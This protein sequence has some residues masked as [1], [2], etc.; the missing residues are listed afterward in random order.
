MDA[1][2]D[3]DF[4]RSDR[5]TV[6]RKLGAGGMGVVFEA[7][8]RERS[9]PVALK[10]LHRM[11]P[12]RLYA[13]KREFRSLADLRHPNLIS[14]GELCCE[15]G[16]WFFTMELIRGED[17]LHH[18]W[19]SASGSGFDPDRLLRALGGLARGIHALHA[20]GKIHRDIK[21]SNVMVDGGG[22]VVLL[23]FGLASDLLAP[24]ASGE[25]PR[26]G[27]PRYM[28]PEVAAGAEPGPP[29]DWYSVGAVLHCALTGHPPD[30]VPAPPPSVPG[31]HP[32]L[33]A[34]WQLC[35]DLLREDPSAR[36]TGAQVLS[37]LGAGD[38]RATPAPSPAVPFVGRAAE[39]AT[40]GD[41]AARGEAALVLV[42]GASGLG[43][44]ALARRFAE[45]LR[46]RDP[47]ALAL[48]GR[49]YEQESVPH[50]AFDGAVDALSRHL[51]ALPEADCA[52]LLPEDAELLVR[53]FP[54]LARVPSMA[55]LP[56]AAAG[57]SPAQVRLRAYEAFRRLLHGLGRR[58]PLLLCLD[59]LQWADADSLELLRALLKDPGA[60]PVLVVATRRPPREGEG[61]GALGVDRPA[62]HL[63]LS[64][65]PAPDARRLAEAA[66]AAAGP[67]ADEVVKESG[68]H[69]LYLQL[70]ARHARPGAAPARLDD[71]VWATASSLDAPARRLLEVL[72]VA[73]GPLPQRA[74]ADAAG[75][76]PAELKHSL[77]VLAAERLLS[78]GADDAVEP[79]HDRV[80]EAVSAHLDDAARRALHQSLARAL[81]AGA[82][83]ESDPRQLVV[84]LEATGETAR[85]ADL[86]ERSARR[87]E[88]QLAFDLAI[89]LYRRAL[90]LGGREASRRTILRLALAQVLAYAGRGTEAAEVFLAVAQTAEPALALEARRHAAEQLLGSGHLERGLQ[91]L[92]QV[93]AE[94]GV[95][96]PP[97]ANRAIASL[98]WQRA[99]LALR[100]FSWAERPAA[101]VPARALMEIDTL[102]SVGMA[103]WP[104]DQFRGVSFVTRS[105]RLALDAG[106]RSRVALAFGLE[107][108][109]W[110]QLGRPPR[111]R[112]RAEE[113]RRIAAPVADE[114]LGA[115]LLALDGVGSY[116]VGSFEESDQKLLEAEGRR[117]PKR[118]SSWQLNV[119]RLMR[120]WALRDRGAYGALAAVLDAQLKEAM[121]RGDQYAETN[122][123]RVC[124]L[125]WLAR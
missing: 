36:P 30:G 108:I 89:E 31:E 119:F 96:G 122:L 103:L 55:S 83:A 92:S 21:P 75:L 80:K 106:E 29:S 110:A 17:F 45:V 107:A 22:R 24:D 48:F 116:C 71:V 66:G 98:F 100:G 9:A 57:A 109:Y 82:A 56:P 15:G 65:L 68:G 26:A 78:V 16:K 99:R 11:D 70:L 93:L 64:P 81:E 44:S 97:T 25:D 62:H 4:P 121:G 114:Q 39:L 85:A 10:T 37:R 60:P 94:L 102:R 38:A 28:A 112:A 61:P 6:L 23:D 79:Y 72:S 8:D 41:A 50:K 35:V 118:I 13:L 84:H 49:C 67:D 91:L 95:R 87:A 43:K 113:A 115:L 12:E 63:Q 53:L 105:Q 32:V 5:F 19:G 52:A 86:A 111:Y 76:S 73:A 2:A 104:V 77:S 34:L 123:S 58:G 120:T 69:P 3:L 124:N 27:T 42:E 59:D 1:G 74:A 47:G 40:L 33:R 18:A 51:R 101:Q 54:V 20:R 88:E 46:E 14:L 90:A 117:D 7:Y 125:V